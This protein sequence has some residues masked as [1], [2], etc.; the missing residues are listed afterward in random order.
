MKFEFKSGTVRSF[1]LY[2]CSF[3]ESRL[4]VSWCAGGRCGM[5]ATTRIVIGVGDLVQRTGDSRTG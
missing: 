2:L 5:R 4:F 3:G 1:Y